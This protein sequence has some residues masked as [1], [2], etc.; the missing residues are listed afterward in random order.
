MSRVSRAL[1]IGGALVAGPAAINAIIGTRRRT[2]L[3]PLPGE[4]RDYAWNWGRVKYYTAGQGEPLL[5]LHGMYAGASAFE[6]RENFEALSQDFRVYAPDL[7]GF[8]LSDKPNVPYSANLYVRLIEDFM[9]EVIGEP[10][11]I[12]ASSISAACCVA[13]QPI[14][15]MARKLAL[16]CPTGIQHLRDPHAIGN[17]AIEKA[18][19][20]PVYGKSFY[21]ALT[22]EAGIRHYLQN[23]VYHDPRLVTDH[24]VHYLH[25]VAHQPGA[26]YA[27]RAM[28]AGKLNLDISYTFWRLDKPI[29][30]LWGRHATVTP[31]SDAREFQER[32][33]HTDLHI[34]ENSGLLPHVE[35]S[36][37]FNETLA[38][39]F[40]VEAMALR[41][42]NEE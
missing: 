2:P 35:E 39:F 3:Q 37:E 4:M 40:G 41:A 17:R 13:A 1:L 29:L 27:V 42:V 12:C 18:L 9:R 25:A 10:T 30:L 19:K 32:N 8:G 36:G 20:T 33:P 24:E 31:V 22:S 28:I 6:W 5:L 15:P 26:H 38:S 11:L 21:Y 34:F 7:L 16:I 23:E 14:T